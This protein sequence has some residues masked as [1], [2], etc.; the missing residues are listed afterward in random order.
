[1]GAEINFGGFAV[2]GD[3]EL[4]LSPRVSVREISRGSEAPRNLVYRLP[5]AAAQK[6][7][8][9]ICFRFRTPVPHLND[10]FCSVHN[11]A[12]PV[13]PSIAVI[14]PGVARCHLWP[15]R[16][17][18]IGPAA[19]GTFRV[20]PVRR[21]QIRNREPVP[22]SG[23]PASVRPPLARSP[24]PIQ[25]ARAEIPGRNFLNWSG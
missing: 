14:R 23:F 22:E 1:M 12:R 4:R 6:A 2:S 15:P 8:V 9:R 21:V 19:P 7:K 17:R 5:R 18:S 13:F 24:P 16:P 10:A 25:T 20:T 3:L 11:R